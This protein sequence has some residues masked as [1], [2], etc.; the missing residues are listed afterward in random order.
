MS[1]ETRYLLDEEQNCVYEFIPVSEDTETYK[2]QPV[3]GAGFQEF[4]TSGEIDALSTEGRMYEL[5]EDEMN[6]LED[7]YE[8][9]E[10][11]ANKLVREA[12]DLLETPFVELLEDIKD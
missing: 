1:T 8:D 5:S 7:A 6:A 12:K 11:E 9:V 3:L 4:R 2:Q 10:E